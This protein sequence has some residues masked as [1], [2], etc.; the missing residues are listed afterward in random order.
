MLIFLEYILEIMFLEVE[1]TIS[2]NM[3][4]M[5]IIVF[6]IVQNLRIGH[7]RMHLIKEL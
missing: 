7:I 2:L 3:I 1:N 4:W 5:L 6:M